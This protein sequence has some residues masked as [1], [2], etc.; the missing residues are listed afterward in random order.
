MEPLAD[1]IWTVLLHSWTVHIIASKAFSEVPG[2]LNRA[3]QYSYVTTGLESACYLLCSPCQTSTLRPRRTFGKSLD[4]FGVP[5]P[6]ARARSMHEAC[7]AGREGER[8]LQG[9]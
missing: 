7:V 5:K 1:G 8:D 4:N 6:S 3:A 2:V 9:E